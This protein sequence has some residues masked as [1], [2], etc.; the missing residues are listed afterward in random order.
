MKNMQE[1]KE[2]IEILN[3]NVITR[4]S[5]LTN[6]IESISHE[7]EKLECKQ[8]K[9]LLTKTRE[10]YIQEYRKSRLKIS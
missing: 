8:A 4:T 5:S 10:E 1:V 2:Y 3:R 7:I 6:A 9:S